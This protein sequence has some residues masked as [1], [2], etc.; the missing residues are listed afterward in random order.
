[1]QRDIFL[2]FFSLIYLPLYLVQ[3][4]PNYLNFFPPKCAIFLAAMCMPMPLPVVSRSHQSNAQ[5]SALGAPDGTF[6]PRAY[7]Y[8]H[9]QA[10]RPSCAASAFSVTMP[11]ALA[12]KEK[13][14]IESFLH[15]DYDNLY[16]V[17]EVAT[18]PISLI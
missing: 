16:L 9:P 1:M 6:V 4:F 17:I 7:T 15:H 18:F 12:W 13:T 5:Q 11:C 2:Y 10:P 3:I 14:G 8:P